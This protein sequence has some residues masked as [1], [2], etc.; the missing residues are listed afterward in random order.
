MH[1]TVRKL[2]FKE[3]AAADEREWRNMSPEER[4]DQVQA[5]RE[6]YWE[7][8]GEIRTGLQ[9]VCQVLERK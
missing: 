7:F 8:K 2:S 3:A 4:L 5:L 9:R 1:N 6:L